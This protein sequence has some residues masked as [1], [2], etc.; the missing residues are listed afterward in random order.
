MSLKVEDRR[1][2]KSV[3]TVESSIITTEEKE[4]I[5]SNEGLDYETAAA[6][7]T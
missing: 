5:E 2:Y 6:K 7:V 1:Q 3:I 4:L